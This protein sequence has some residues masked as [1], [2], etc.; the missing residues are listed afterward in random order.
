MAMGR[1]SF[2]SDHEENN[3]SV[4]PARRKC[5]ADRR[6][7]GPRSARIATAKHDRK[8]HT[9]DLRRVAK[10]FRKYRSC[11]RWQWN[12]LLHR[13]AASTGHRR[14]WRRLGLVAVVAN[15]ARRFDVGLPNSA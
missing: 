4:A 1:F 8:Y 15:I 14:E 12:G 13:R 11:G 6:G 2:G 10:Q 5:S 9:G 7:P 3:R